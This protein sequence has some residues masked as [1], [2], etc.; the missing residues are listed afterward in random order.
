M[1]LISI[2]GDFDSSIF[3]IFFNFKHKLTHH[4]ILHD[5]SKCD[6]NYANK[7]IK[8]QVKFKKL[9]N[10]NY[11]IIDMTINEDNFDNISKAFKRIITKTKKPKNIYLNATDGLSSVNIVLSSKLL[12]YGG[13]VIVYDRFVNTYNLHTKTTI[14]TLKIKHNTDIKNHLLLKGYKIINFSNIYALSNR[15]K[16]IISLTKNL[17]KFKDYANSYKV[18]T[19]LN[20]KFGNILKDI[21]QTSE[22]FVKGTVFEEYIFWL[23]KDNIKV[24]DIMVCVSLEYEKNVQNEFDI[25]FI[26]NNHLYTIECKF[27]KNFKTTEYLYK[28]NYIIDAL[29]DDGKGMILTIG[30]KNIGWQDEARA[31]HSNI[32]FY[33]APSEDFNEKQFLSQIKSFFNLKAK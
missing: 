32:D 8:A 17:K 10:Y 5:D 25:L 19:N 6:K 2:L 30:T 33:S 18:G 29:D 7:I 23:I 1:V 11:E 20:N 12:E 27:T 26:K 15:K 21:N 22:Q 28:L 24:D 9:Y 3:P 14:K 4:I 16:A 13:K 31:I